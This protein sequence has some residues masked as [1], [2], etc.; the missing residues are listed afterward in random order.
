MRTT[1][2]LR[3]AYDWVLRLR[4]DGG[5]SDQIGLV[6]KRLRLSVRDS[7]FC[8][9]GA[10]PGLSFGTM[11]CPRCGRSWRID[12]SRPKR[13]ANSSGVPLFYQVVVRSTARNAAAVR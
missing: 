6:T 1:G 9:G 3:H 10:V 7:N 2:L 4:E 12:V 11:G 5:L 13:D 8:L